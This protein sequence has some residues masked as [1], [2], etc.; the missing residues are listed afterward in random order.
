MDAKLLDMEKIS[1]VLIDVGASSAPHAWWLPIAAQSI[2]VGFD[3][4]SR[5]LNEPIGTPFRRVVIINKAVS[6]TDEEHV[7]FFLTRSPYCSS[8]LHPD[9]DSLQPFSHADLFTVESQGQAPAITLNR[10]LEELGLTEVDALKIDS[11]G[12]D[13]R[14]FMSLEGWKRGKVLALDVEPGLIDA[15]LGEDL[16]VDTHRALK[17]AGF[18]LSTLDVRGVAR[19]SSQ[20]FPGF[21]SEADRA[22]LLRV[23]KQTPGWCEA[24]YLRRVETLDPADRRS[25]ILLFTFALLDSQLGYASEVVTI[26]RKHHGDDS[27]ASAMLLQLDHEMR[28]LIAHSDKMEA[29]RRFERP[30]LRIARGLWRLAGL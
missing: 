10:A 14:L 7:R 12:T 26:Y 6:P 3:A 19:V 8:T 20:R 24:R 15:Y 18:W 4:D 11:Q 17:N 25:L 16:F 9:N 28:T 22:A 30:F 23:H 21:T 13:L 29:L 2:Y 27:A 1:P 5:D